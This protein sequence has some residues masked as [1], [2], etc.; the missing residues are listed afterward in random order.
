LEL[1]GSPNE[2][3]YKLGFQLKELIQ[4][5]VRN[6]FE[7]MQLLSPL[8]PSR[9]M[10]LKLISKYVPYARTYAP[11]LVEEIKGIA[12]GADSSFQEVFFLNSFDDIAADTS[13]PMLATK[14]FGCTSFATS[15]G[16]TT[17]DEAFIGQNFDYNVI[18]QDF[19]IIIKAKNESGRSSLIYTMAGMLGFIGQ[20]SSGISV[21]NNKLFSSDPRPGVPFTLI[22][23][24][25]LEQETIEDAINVVVNAHR[26][27]GM[28]Y[29]ICDSYGK[30]VNI[31][32]T[33]AK[34]EVIY[35]TAGYITHTNHYITQKLKSY[36]LMEPRDSIVRND[37]MDKLVCA[38]AKNGE[39]T[40]EYL[41][42]C[43]KDHAN[44]PKS[45]CNHLDEKVPS[46]KRMKTISAL[47]MQPKRRKIWVTNGNPCQNEFS[48]YTM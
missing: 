45:I 46:Y 21:A 30:V 10:C 27:T 48:E 24:R 41:K 34:Y 19:P 44:Y 12:E 14:F 16:V 17:N 7:R 4:K 9:E 47:I 38:R 2:V 1:R 5:E 29:L 18:F 43:L 20:N 37:R 40:Y 13:N 22:I 11:E 28:N 6:L 8:S 23:R 31:E 42:E 35:P 36:Q 3:G 25:I 32:T 33:A 15:G 39:I 26:T